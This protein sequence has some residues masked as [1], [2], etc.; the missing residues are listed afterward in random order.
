MK[1]RFPEQDKIRC[2]DATRDCATIM[3]WI[4]SKGPKGISWR[5]ERSWMFV[6]D[7]KWSAE[8]GIGSN[9]ASNEVRITGIIR[10][11]DLNSDRLVHVGDWGDYQIDRI[12]AKSSESSHTGKECM[13]L[14]SSQ[15]RLLHEPTLDQDD[16]ADLAPEE[17]AMEDVEVEATSTIASERRGV[18]LDDH[19]YFDEDVEDKPELPKRLPRGT[20][21]YQSAWYLGDVSDS[22]SDVEDV[23]EITHSASL[24]DSERLPDSWEESMFEDH[25]MSDAGPSEYP[26][27]EM[28]LEPS[29][30]E[31]AE[32]LAKY[33]AQKKQDAEDDSVFPDEVELRPDILAR[34]RLARY[35][36]LRS[37]QT[38]HWETEEDKFYEPE[39]WARL[40]EIGNYKAAKNRFTK[41]A[42]VNGVKPGT[43]V[44][45][46]LRN[47][48]AAMQR[49]AKTAPPL[50][51]FSLLRHEHK[52]TAVNFDITLN[53]TYPEH[54]KSKE[55][56]LLQCGPRRFVINPLFSQGGET[57][58]DVHK[59]ER[60][61][62]PGQSAV[63][64]FIGPVNWGAVPSLF[65]K[66]MGPV[67]PVGSGM[68]RGT[69]SLSTSLP[70]SSEDLALVATGTSLAP[71]TTRV[72]AKRIILTGH[73]YKIHKKLVTVRYMFFNAEDVQWF[74]A[75]QLWTRRGRTGHVKESLGTHGYFKAQFDAKINPMDAIAISLYK[76]MWPRRVRS[77]FPWGDGEMFKET[78]GD[79]EREQVGSGDRLGQ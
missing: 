13:E 65:F 9:E 35:R 47:V 18:L 78:N 46:Y 5:D 32:E 11:Q 50:T 62:H 3:Q 63:A 40:L 49:L 76:R 38:S 16:L 6:E 25:P 22:G 70:S 31:E 72:I 37:L 19:H 30:D 26:H 42:L 39:E 17:I 60:F 10:G 23:N 8:N 1:Q 36:G 64:T 51:L 56:L 54:L 33:R 77:W 73:P 4:C 24:Q 75:L 48:P 79:S 20:S 58:N 12:V 41:E 69:P 55:E 43:R 74:K 2:L 57:P 53:S 66:R 21:H 68:E 44:H 52:Q 15:E 45:I 29:P 67:T 7:V 14:D 61:L 28:L 27:S 59:F 71:S 34:E